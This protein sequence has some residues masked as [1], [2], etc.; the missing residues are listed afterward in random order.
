[1]AK[2][3]RIATRLKGS[4]NSV[5]A[6][7]IAHSQLTGAGYR[8]TRFAFPGLAQ[9]EV[10]LDAQK[11]VC[12]LQHLT[13]LTRKLLAGGPQDLQVLCEILDPTIK[14]NEALQ[15]TPIGMRV[16]TYG[17]RWCTPKKMEKTKRFCSIARI[18][19]PTNRLGLNPSDEGE[20]LY[21][22]G[23]SLIFTKNLVAVRWQGKVRAYCSV[24]EAATG[25]TR[26]VMNTLVLSEDEVRGAIAQEKAE[27]EAKKAAKAAAKQAKKQKLLAGFQGLREKAQRSRAEKIWFPIARQIDA[28]AADEVHKT[29]SI[30][31]ERAKMLAQLVRPTEGPSQE[32]LTYWE[33]EL[34][35][36]GSDETILNLLDLTEGWVQE[37]STLSLAERMALAGPLVIDLQDGILEIRAEGLIKPQATIVP[38]QAAREFLSQEAFC[39]V[40]GSALWWTSLPD[41]TRKE[42]ESLLRSVEEDKSQD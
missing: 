35:W 42:V 37:G 30:L 32:A 11:Q 25:L 12:N 1:M 29:Y 34:A 39:E 22:T 41:E 40:F 26:R 8:E 13:D 19:D 5:D 7:R 21:P 17:D 9:W 33:D 36:P 16:S 28:L 24:W 10:Q 2:Y 14:G 4:D 3:K 23:I 15:Y 20:M 27:K 38:Y 18:D 31:E 6:Q